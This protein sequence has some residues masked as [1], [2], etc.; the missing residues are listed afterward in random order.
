MEIDN[1][2]ATCILPE[3]IVALPHRSGLIEKE[4]DNRAPTLILPEGIV[5]LI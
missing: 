5:A 2:T 1:R 3:G 4:R